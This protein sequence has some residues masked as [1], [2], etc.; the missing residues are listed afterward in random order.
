M[1]V[2]SAYIVAWAS[3]GEESKSLIY[4]APMLKVHPC[5]PMFNVQLHLIVIILI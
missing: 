3:R 1:V 2:S 4:S 5:V